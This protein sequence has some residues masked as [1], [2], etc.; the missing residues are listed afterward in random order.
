[1][2]D[3]NPANDE[4]AMARVWRDGQRKLCYVYR[5]V[6][7]AS[8]EEKILQRQAHKKAL[9]SCVVDEQ[10]D[11]EKHF[12]AAEL[13]NLFLLKEGTLSDTHDQ[14]KCKKC[15]LFSVHRQQRGEET[16][17][18]IPADFSLW[19]HFT[20]PS[21]LKVAYFYFIFLGFFLPW[22]CS[23]DDGAGSGFERGG[24]QHCVVCVSR[25]VARACRCV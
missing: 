14:F 12:T 13:K 19:D 20:N 16:C 23:N 22:P 5:F 9:S 7:T 18:G 15:D 6:A 4:Q 11:V 1:L 24:G 8:I 17:I 3:W 25:P 21:H 2:E 10:E